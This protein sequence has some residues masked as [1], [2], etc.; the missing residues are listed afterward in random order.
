MII[1]VLFSMFLFWSVL[2]ADKT[3]SYHLGEGVQ[4]ASFP[5]YIGGYISTDYRN[6]NGENRYRLDDLALLSYGNYNKFSYMA[7]LEYKGFYVLTENAG[8]YTTGQDRTLHTERLYVN[9]AFDE[10]YNFRVGKY[11]TPAGFWNL[12]PIN[13]LRDT[14]SIPQS[15]NLLFPKFT[16]GVLLSYKSYDD[17]N[18][19]VDVM[20]QNN[21]DLDATYNNYNMDE[22]YGIG[23][24]YEKNNLALKFNFGL[25][26][27]LFANNSSQNLYYY[28]ASFKY[29]TEKIE[30][31]GE[32]GS[33]KIAH[34]YTTKYAGFLQGLYRFTQK[35]AGVLRL[36]SYD[37]KKTATL[38]DIAIFAY[39]Y[40]PLYPISIKAEYQFHSIHKNNQALVSFSVLF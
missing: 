6:F 10:N 9:Y 29:E 27:G 2:L 21:A 8:T 13:V 15:T 36:E 37:N 32:L 34:S 19:N 24:G 31:L 40:R 16:T 17:A 18:F 3:D 11:S 12:L 1:K 14:T 7:E 28:M 30:L 4:V 25:F 39:S 22:H 20:L 38:E 26:D 5:M 23:F 35:H 33:Q